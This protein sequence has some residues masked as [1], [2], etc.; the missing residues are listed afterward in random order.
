MA[1]ARIIDADGHIF[2]DTEEMTKRMPKAFH[3]WKYT[4]NVF[5]RQPW[6]PPLGHLHTPTGISPK[7]AFGA[8]GLPG[9]D[10]W[11]A[12]IEA[13]GIE[14]AALY[15]TSGLTFGHIADRDYAICVARSYNDW[16]AET[17][18][19]RSPV[20]KGMGMI[21]MQEPEAAI[22]ELRRCILELNMTGIVLPGTGLKAHLGSKECCPIYAEAEQL[23]C[24]LAIHGG[25]HINFGMD[26]MN[27]FAPVHAIG[28]PLSMI[29][30][31]GGLVFNGVF[32]KFPKLRFGFLEA[33][34]AWLLFC[35]ER[36]DSSH[37][38]FLPMNWRGELLKLKKGQTVKGYMLK[39]IKDSRLFVGCEGDEFMLA[40]G[41]KAVGN[42][43]FMYSSDFPH[44]VNTE[45][46]LHHLEEI[47]EHEELSDDDRSAILHGNAERFYRVRA[48]TVRRAAAE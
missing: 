45:T 29:I 47:F 30:A 33:G 43:A 34:V 32:D 15:P 26:N 21:P 37:Q 41:I 27:V 23:G 7:G 39:L 1:R 11:M 31:L 2:E 3:E 35:I 46:C 36:F 40:A 28:H 44:E 8:G 42:T 6:F 18:V 24:P 4:H 48:R 20:F 9:I 13:T 22:E 25:N 10:A 5:A 19:D 12:F 14:S 16:L 38:G 17:Y